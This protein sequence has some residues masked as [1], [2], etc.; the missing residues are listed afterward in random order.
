MR[1]HPQIQQVL[2]RT[3]EQLACLVHAHVSDRH[4]LFELDGDASLPGDTVRLTFEAAQ[5]SDEIAESRHTIEFMALT[6]DGHW[7]PVG[8]IGH[9]MKEID[10]MQGRYHLI[11]SAFEVTG[12]GIPH[13]CF[14]RAEVEAVVQSHLDRLAAARLLPLRPIRR[15]QPLAAWAAL[16]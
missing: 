9:S 13:G 1:S 16:N 6:G 12:P 5:G 8:T 3:Q 7:T 2:S 14:R 4:A 11:E 15:L 10:A